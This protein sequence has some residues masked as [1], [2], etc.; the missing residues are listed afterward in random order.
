[1]RHEGERG[2]LRIQEGR[3]CRD[4]GAGREGRIEKSRNKEAGR[5]DRVVGRQ[6]RSSETEKCKEGSK[7][8]EP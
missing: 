1:M 4:G 8:G 5:R 3:N 6:A 2:K 7:K